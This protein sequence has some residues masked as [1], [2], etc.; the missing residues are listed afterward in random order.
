MFSERLQIIKMK[1]NTWYSTALRAFDSK[2]ASRRDESF[3]G[4]FLLNTDVMINSVSH[5]S[6]HNTLTLLQNR[7]PR[8]FNLVFLISNRANLRPLV[9]SRKHVND[10]WQGCMLKLKCFEM[11]YL[12]ENCAPDYDF[13]ASKRY[14]LILLYFKKI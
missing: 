12:R 2:L 1:F 13:I 14:L 8:G 7:V 11:Y 3:Q 6:H 4:F 5:T 9:K 10:S